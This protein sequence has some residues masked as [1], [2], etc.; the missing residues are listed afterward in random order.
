MFENSY[1]IVAIICILVIV[2]YGYTFISQKTKIPSVLMLLFTGIIAKLVLSYLGYE[3]PNMQILLEVFGIIGIIL[4]VLEGTLELKLERSK[5]KL[6]RKSFGSALMALLISS[7]IIALIFKLILNVPF[8]TCLVNA[9]PFAVISS[10]I[11]IPSVMSFSGHKREF[12]IYESTFSDILGIML[13]N[14]VVHNSTFTVHSFSWLAIDFATVL[15]ISLVFSMLLM[16]YIA[17]SKMNIKFFLLISILILL[18]AFGKLVH[19]SSLLLILIF[20]LVLN[21]LNLI[22]KDKMNKFINLENL[23]IGI[24]QFKLIIN[25]SAFLIRTFFFFIFGI[26]FT[27]AS[28]ANLTVILIGIVIIIVLYGIRFLYLKYITRFQL[29]PNLLIA[30]RGLI[31]VLLYYSI[32]EEYSIGII[33]QGVLFF[34]IIVSSVIM[35]IGLLKSKETDVEN[36][37]QSSEEVELEINSTDSDINIS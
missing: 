10:A 5:L 13:F 26:T 34:V 19:L 3:L 24:G 21:N 29:F 32:P 6:I 33:S 16:F 18:Y 12:I 22:W 8:Q 7:A 30:P 11:A 9:I 2:S 37:E 23:N 25:E 31:T 27:F 28:I 14:I 15:V 20:G 1:I 17:K 36:I 4:I 35:M